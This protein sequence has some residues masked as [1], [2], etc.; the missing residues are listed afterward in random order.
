MALQI[1]DCR[2]KDHVDTGI[3]IWISFSGGLAPSIFRK[4]TDGK[5]DVHL[6]PEQFCFIEVLIQKFFSLFFTLT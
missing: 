1:V 3:S 4:E 2:N 6:L 5:M